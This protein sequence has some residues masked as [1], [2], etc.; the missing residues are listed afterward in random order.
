MGIKL[1]FTIQRDVFNIEIVGREVFYSDRIWKNKIR[2]VP[3]DEGFAKKIIMSRNRM[4]N[5]NLETFKILFTLTPEE[6][7]E[8]NSAKTEAELADI[9]VKDVRKKGGVLRKRDENEN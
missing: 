5:V 2:L 3:E 8:Y 6:L 7:E 1:V 4:P 9:C